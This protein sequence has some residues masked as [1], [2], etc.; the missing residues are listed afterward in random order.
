MPKLKNRA[1]FKRINAKLSC[2]VN[3]DKNRILNSLETIMKG[4]PDYPEIWHTN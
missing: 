3:W 2:V 4:L 1:L